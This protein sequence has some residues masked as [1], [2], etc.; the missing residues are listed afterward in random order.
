MGTDYAT[1][2][3]SKAH[4]MIDT[5]SGTSSMGNTQDGSALVPVK[6]EPSHRSSS[7]RCLLYFPSR[8]DMRYNPS[9]HGLLIYKIYRKGW[10]GYLQ[11]S[12]SIDT[13]H[14]DAGMEY[15]GPG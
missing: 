12:T 10:L 2:I 15:S 13:L 9:H 11:S 5:H 6:P 7:S 1:R 4:N 3:D 8:A 14:C